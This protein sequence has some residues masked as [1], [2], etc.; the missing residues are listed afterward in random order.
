MQQKDDSA[1]LKIKYILQS[2]DNAITS[3]L[4]YEIMKYLLCAL[5]R[6]KSGCQVF[7]LSQISS[8]S[9]SCFSMNRSNVKHIEK[10]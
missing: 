10:Y 2:F 5:E 4:C 7:A 8:T 3:V 1:Q 6:R 9:T